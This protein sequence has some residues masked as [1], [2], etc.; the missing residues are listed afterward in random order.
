MKIVIAPDAFK[1]C[2]PAE[3]VCKALK[4]GILQANPT[5]EVLCVPLADGG[6]GTADCFAAATDGK[7]VSVQVQNAYGTPKTAQYIL[8]ADRKTALVEM[9]QASGIQG[10]DKNYLHTKNA[11]T[12]GTGELI[13]HAVNKGA[14]HIIVGLGGSATTDGGMGAL[15]ALGVRFLDMFGK[16]LSPIGAH[17]AKVAAIEVPNNPFFNGKIRFTYACDVQNPFYGETGAA[18]VFARQKGA[19]EAEIAE[20]DRGLRH[21]AV[22]YQMSFRRDIANLPSMGAA[23]GLC[24]GLFAAFG[25]TVQSGFEMLA[26]LTDLER[27]IAAADLVLTGEGRTDRQTAFGKLPARVSLYAAKHGAPCVLISGDIAPDFDATAAGFSAA[28]P[29]KTENMTAAYSIA[30][31]QELLEE[32]IFTYLKKAKISEIK[33]SVSTEC[34]KF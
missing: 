31:A 11:S 25:G 8:S 21:L 1:D 18:F 29:L 6:E 30:H 27:E 28:I 23:G 10:I 12:Y 14:E 26:D 15:A 9:A 24:G 33:S 22:Q 5:A 2:L 19:T 13:L 4:N 17:M 16:E 3:A 20:L 7:R 32:A 34:V